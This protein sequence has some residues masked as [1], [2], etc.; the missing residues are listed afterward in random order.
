MKIYFQD[1][2]SSLS[3]NTTRSKS[4]TKMCVVCWSTYNAS[5]VRQKNC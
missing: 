5:T 3:P 2:K 4:R 1:S